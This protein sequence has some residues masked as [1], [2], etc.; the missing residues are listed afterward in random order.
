[1]A[2]AQAL[3]WLLSLRG[4]AA[5]QQQQQYPYDDSTLTLTSFGA[6]DPFVT[7]FRGQYY[8]TFT[9]GDRIEI[10]SSQSLVDIETTGFRHRI[11]QPPPGTTHSADIWAPE[12]HSL[13]GRWYIYYTAADPAHGNKSH[14]LYV[15]G[16]PSTERDPCSG[17]W[18]FLGPVYPMPDQWAIDGTVFGIGDELYLAYSGW[19]LHRSELHKPEN[20]DFKN[21]GPTQHTM[22]GGSAE[23]EDWTT[24]PAADDAGRV[25]HLYIVRLASPCRASSKPVLVGLPYQKWE[26]THDGNGAHAINEGPQWLASPDGRWQGLVYSCGG[27]WTHDYKMATLRYRGGDPLDP[28][29]WRKSETPLL[30]MH[31]QTETG[32]FGPGHGSFLH[33]GGE[34][35]IAVYH[36]TDGPDDGWGNRRARIQRVA[37]T[38]RGPYMGKSFGVDG[39]FQTDGMLARMAAKLGPKK[40]APTSEDRTEGFRAFME[41][42]RI[43]NQAEGGQM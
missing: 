34:Y 32:P 31:K 13:R 39:P 41:A 38:E 30:Q 5:M 18:E 42:R 27:S 22:A 37:F 1:M 33:V 36:A 23:T 35:V 15:L 17:E 9:A 24:A 25:Q 8:F 40:R 16:G 14:R 28:A 3:I 43:E 21:Q 26:I 10:W 6:P 11:W 2:L 7:C 12:L 20:K 4:L 19:P 29:S